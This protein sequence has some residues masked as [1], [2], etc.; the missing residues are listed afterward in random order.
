MHV[1]QYAY[2]KSFERVRGS[3][4]IDD[5]NVKHHQIIIAAQVEIVTNWKLVM[6]YLP[7]CEPRVQILHL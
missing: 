7:L 1:N 3:P 5:P 2:W 6:R 4:Y